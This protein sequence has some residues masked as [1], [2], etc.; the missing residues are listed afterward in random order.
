[1]YVTE[2]ITF[3]NFKNKKVSKLIIIIIDN[4]KKYK[5]IFV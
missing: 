3:I 2:K 1:M 4:N 5:N